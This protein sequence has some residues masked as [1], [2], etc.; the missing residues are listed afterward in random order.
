LG[1]VGDKAVP[2]DYDGDGRLDAAVFRSNGSW[3]IRQ[4]STGTQV[5]QALG[6]VAGDVPVPGD[7]DGDGRTDAAIFR[8]GTATWYVLNQLQLAFGL[9]TDIPILKRP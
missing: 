5:T 2:G 8:P 6:G 7:Y 4:S 3:F 9:S 1:A